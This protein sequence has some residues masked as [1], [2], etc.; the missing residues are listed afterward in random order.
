MIIKKQID[1]FLV[2]DDKIFLLALKADIE[3][4]FNNMNIKIHSF[5]TGERACKNSHK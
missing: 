4:A 3:E 2:E 1:I 5:S